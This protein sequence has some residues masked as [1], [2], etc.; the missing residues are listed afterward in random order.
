VEKRKNKREKPQ[1][2]VAFEKKSRKKIGE[3]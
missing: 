1:H 2:I 3:K